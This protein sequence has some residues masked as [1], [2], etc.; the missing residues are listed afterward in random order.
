MDFVVKVEKRA[1]LFL[2]LVDRELDPQLRSI[3][4]GNKH[5]APD[6]RSASGAKSP[7]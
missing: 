5:L 7:F 3:S 1:G 2:C 4:S 6:F